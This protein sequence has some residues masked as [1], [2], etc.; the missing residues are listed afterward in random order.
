[1]MISS[2][3]YIYNGQI[4]LQALV[5]TNGMELEEKSKKEKRSSKPLF[6]KQRRKRE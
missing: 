2:K 6:E 4:H 1:M 3:I 5:L